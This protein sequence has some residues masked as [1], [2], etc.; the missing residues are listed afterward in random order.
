MTEQII[1]FLL[2]LASSPVGYSA[3]IANAPY[4]FG[5]IDN[6]RTR[7]STKPN[8]TENRLNSPS[9]RFFCGCS[10]Q[11]KRGRFEDHPFFQPARSIRC[12]LPGMILF[13]TAGYF[14]FRMSFRCHGQRY[15][16]HIGKMFMQNQYTGSSSLCKTV[17]ST[18]A[19]SSQLYG[20]PSGHPDID[21]L[22]C[23][24]LVLYSCNPGGA[25]PGP[26][27]IRAGSGSSAIFTP[28]GTNTSA[29]SLTKLV[30]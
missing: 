11:G 22:Q 17:R 30:P 18:C 23:I 7:G 4:L 16:W 12:L 1:R 6:H 9:G 29:S 8:F 25:I 20:I 28:A 26:S 14:F 21:G 5:D 19:V 10:G 3:N 2:Q 24:D 27:L 13:Q 15:M